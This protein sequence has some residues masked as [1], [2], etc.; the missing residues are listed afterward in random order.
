MIRPEVQIHLSVIYTLSGLVSSS[1]IAQALSVV[2]IL[3]WT[4]GVV[5]VNVDVLTQDVPG[6]TDGRKRSC[7]WMFVMR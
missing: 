2:F 1:R 3:I 7:V 5:A 6:Y 4:I